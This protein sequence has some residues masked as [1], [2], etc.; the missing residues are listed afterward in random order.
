MAEHGEIVYDTASGNDYEAHEAAY[1][2][3]IN[4][5]KYGTG[6]VIVVVILMALFLL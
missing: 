1:R 5:A 2:S 6:T 4:L 3:F